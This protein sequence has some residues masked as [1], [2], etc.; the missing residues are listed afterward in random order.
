M[1][2]PKMANHGLLGDTRTAK[3]VSTNPV[4]RYLRTKAMKDE[5]GCSDSAGT[6]ITWGWDLEA[7]YRRAESPKN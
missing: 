2:R 1:K 5:K 7:G 6:S 4:R 3:V